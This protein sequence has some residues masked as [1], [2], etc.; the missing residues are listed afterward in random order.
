MDGP[1][2][3]GVADDAARN[4]AISFLGYPGAWPALR[5]IRFR[6]VGLDFTDADR[7]ANDLRAPGLTVLD[8]ALSPIRP[9]AVR[10]LAKA[11]H[12]AP[13][14]VVRLRRMR[15]DNRGLRYLARAKFWKNLVELDLRGNPIDENG[16]KFLLERRPPPELELLTLDRNFP[17]AVCGR[18]QDHF[19]GKVV[20]AEK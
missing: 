20:F 13:L 5:T 6:G 3:T 17:D 10:A 19:A 14:R 18:L 2:E 1:P 8:L 7:L 4:P 11:E 16:A 12:L 9:E 15:I